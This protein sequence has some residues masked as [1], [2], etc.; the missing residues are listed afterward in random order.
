MLKYYKENRLA[1]VTKKAVSV[2][3]H[4]RNDELI[5]DLLSAQLGAFLIYGEEMAG[6]VM[7]LVKANTDLMNTVMHD[8]ERKCQP[9]KI[10]DS[11]E[12]ILFPLLEDVIR[13]SYKTV[14]EYTIGFT[15]V[16]MVRQV[17]FFS[18]RSTVRRRIS[19]SEALAGG[20]FAEFALGQLMK[21]RGGAQVSIKTYLPKRQEL[22][23]L[24]EEKH[25]RFVFI[26]CLY[27][28]Q[29]LFSYVIYSHVTW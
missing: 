21:Y 28:R 22:E 29:E 12:T 20:L 9:N 8:S 16:S 14:K 5:K 25:L 11:F 15:E 19:N 10:Y 7:K 6:K 1:I 17:R 4:L 23:K 13:F 18:G 26:S 27:P 24:V 3:E 2:Y